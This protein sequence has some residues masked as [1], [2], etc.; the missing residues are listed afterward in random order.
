[1]VLHEL[2]TQPGISSKLQS[3]Q[4]NVKVKRVTLVQYFEKLGSLLAPQALR[5]QVGKLILILYFILFYYD[6]SSQ[7]K[8]NNCKMGAQ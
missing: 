4:E 8:T 1:M 3:P 5:I 2:L 7:E 6:H